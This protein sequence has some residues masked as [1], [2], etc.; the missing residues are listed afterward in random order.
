MNYQRLNMAQSRNVRES[1]HQRR[2]KLWQVPN[3][4]Y[5]SIMGICFSK[6]KLQKFKKKKLFDFDSS[7][8]D[9]SAHNGLSA[10]SMNK[11]PQSRMLHKEL[12]SMYQISI[13]KYG[14]CQTPEEIIL[15]WEQDFAEGN[16]AGAYWAIMTH[17][18]SNRSVIERIYGD[19]HMKSFECFASER[20]ENTV[21]RKYREENNKLKRQLDQKQLEL[22][23]MKEARLKEGKAA[24]QDRSELK[25]QRLENDNLVKIN[26]KLM[27]QLAS[28]SSRQELLEIK[29]ILDKERQL[30]QELL[31]QVDKLKAH[32]KSLEQNQEILEE[33]VFERDY[34]VQI[35]KEQNDEQQIELATMEKF[36]EQHFTNQ[37]TPCDNC[38]DGCSCPMNNSLDGKTVLYVGGQRKM[39]AR[40][41]QI[42]EQNGGEFLYH[43]GGVESARH[44][45]PKMLTGADAVF[46]PIDCVSHDACKCVKKICKQYQ[47]P[48][49]LM[50]SSGLSSL[51]KG[52]ETINDQV[53]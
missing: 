43:D 42:I 7:Q 5:C 38:G 8:S 51:A 21:L 33:Q 53:Q 48:F 47:K 44:M 34:E 26:N 14:A 10:L 45:L 13:R 52:L 29:E 17:P 2:K 50:R 3:S 6:A 24:R 19:S 28:Q 39:I 15:Q 27:D 46:C 40:Y 35:L 30:T 1:Y 31:E 41:K 18:E 36:V 20:R 37:G 49:V 4:Y 23:K 16:I 9:Y 22:G 11:T 12:D 25:V 32:V